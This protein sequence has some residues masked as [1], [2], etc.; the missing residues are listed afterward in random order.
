MDKRTPRVLE[1]TVIS[2]EDLRINDRSIKKN[3]FVVV[4]T[5]YSINYRNTCID[6]EGG[7]YPSWNEKL[8]LPL[9]HNVRFIR[10]EVQ[11][12]TGSS[13]RMIGEAKIPISDFIGD[14]IPPHYV[15]FLSY[16]LRQRDG[17]RNGIVNLS[18]RVKVPLYRTFLPSGVQAA[19]ENYDGIAVGIPVSYGCTV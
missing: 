4:Q 17:E 3:A 2:A 5:D 15:H 18:V 13:A 1:V 8:E 19:N 16:R 12:K 7:S 10:V 14:Y 6:T 11:C 9:Y